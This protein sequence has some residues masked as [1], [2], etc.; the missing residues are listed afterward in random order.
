MT[1]NITFY[2]KVYDLDLL[3]SG[4]NSRGYATSTTP[5]S[6]GTNKPFFAAMMQDA[7]AD[8]GRGLLTTST[9]SLT[10]ATGAQVIIMAAEINL[11]VGAYVVLSRTSAPT[12]TKMY[13]QVTSKSGTTLNVT[14]DEISG[15]GTYADW[16]IQISGPVGAVG[17]ATGHPT[18]RTVTAATDTLVIG[19]ADTKIIGDRATVQTITIPPNS[20]VTFTIDTEV[21]FQQ[22]G[23]GQV[24]IAAGSGVTLYY[25]GVS[26]A[27]KSIAA[28]HELCS[29][30]KIG[31]DTWT[32]NGA[33]V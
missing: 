33:V 31:T 14:V 18:N 26:V 4:A 6:G 9:S 21:Y 19:D 1:N 11:G 17:P 5:A 16:T 28:Q 22:W 30:T 12:T 13:G 27:S 7:L 15:S 23:L 3:S 2:G 25:R 24:D 10:V 29:I 20:S 8:A 32:I